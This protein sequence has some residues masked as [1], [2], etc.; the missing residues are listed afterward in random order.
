MRTQWA[1]AGMQAMDIAP[2]DDPMATWCHKERK[3]RHDTV[4]VQQQQGT[5]HVTGLHAE[6]AI[7]EG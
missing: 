4:Q 2:S 1:K 6:V 3:C 7:F 5:N